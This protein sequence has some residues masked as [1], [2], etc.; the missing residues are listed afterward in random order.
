[1]TKNISIL[2][3]KTDFSC[4]KKCGN[5]RK[6]NSIYCKDCHGK[7]CLDVNC[8]NI[9]PNKYCDLHEGDLC[10]DKEC[11]NRKVVGGDCCWMH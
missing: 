6:H 7:K 5:P 11:P 1:M 8:N 4:I 9:V 2:G 3:A 10:N